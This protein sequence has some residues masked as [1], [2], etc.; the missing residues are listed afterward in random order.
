M[1]YEKNVIMK[2]PLKVDIRFASVYPNLYKTAMSSLGYQIIYGMINERKDSWCE[3]VV[4]PD[5]RSI[6]SNSHLKDFDIISFSLQYE[7]DYFN[8]LEMLKKA[9]IPIRRK[10]RKVKNDFDKN[11][12]IH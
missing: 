12:T 5:T 9:E 3:R 10:D 1:I 6:E 2:R 4:Y 8:M 11:L 7:Q